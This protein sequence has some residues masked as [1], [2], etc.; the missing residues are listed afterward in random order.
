VLF[1]DTDKLRQWPR[2][3]SLDTIQ[4]CFA[5]DFTGEVYLGTTINIS[6]TG[7][8]LYT[9]CRLKEGDSIIIKDDV[10]PP[11]RRA[12]VRWVKN[13]G[14]ALCKAGLMFIE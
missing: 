6:N 9:L 5:E 2:T 11:Y 13:Y 12:T 1:Q 14:A 8:C 4:F 7:I 10:P 3:V